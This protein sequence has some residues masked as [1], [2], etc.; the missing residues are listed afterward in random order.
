MQQQPRVLRDRRLQAPSRVAVAPEP[1]VVARD[2]R[3][4][5][6]PRAAGESGARARA[7]RGRRTSARA[8][9]G[10]A[11]S[12]CAGSQRTCP[13]CLRYSDDRRRERDERPARR[14]SQEEEPV[15]AR[16]HVLVETRPPARAADRTTSHRARE[17][18]A[19]LGLRI[20][21]SYARARAAPRE[22]RAARGRPSRVHG[23]RATVADDRAGMASSASRRAERPGEQTSSSSRNATARRARPPSRDCAPPSARPPACTTTRTRGSPIA[24]RRARVAA[25]SPSSATTTSTSTP[26]WASALRTASTH[27]AGPAARRDRDR[28]RG[29]RPGGGCARRR[30]VRG[31]AR[32]VYFMLARSSTSTWSAASTRIQPSRGNS[33]S[34]VTYTAAAVTPAKA[35]RWNQPRSFP[36]AMP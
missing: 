32:A 31:H 21:A 11:A 27:H 25:S 8:A 12:C 15:L 22:L 23:D 10:S 26:S 36:R 5:A 4:A 18:R 33:K 2:V 14:E 30:G 17:Q 3:R 20:S 19:A 13:S 1:A 7:S 24:S 34:I 29:T 9:S 6:A 28:D 35:R 16:R